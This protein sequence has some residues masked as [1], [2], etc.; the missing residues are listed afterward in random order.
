MLSNSSVA[1]GVN[2]AEICSDAGLKLVPKQL[3]LLNELNNSITNN[4]F[5]NIDQ[6]EFIEPA[7]LSSSLGNEQE[8]RIGKV[9]V[10][11]THDGIM[12][13][14]IEDLSKLV[15]GYISFARNVVNKE[16]NLLKENVEERLSNYK[17]KEAEDFFNVKYFKLDNV[18][19][20]Y[21][22]DNE[23]KTYRDSSGKYFFDSMSLRKITEEDFDLCKYILTGD[24]EQ[25]LV[26]QSWFNAVG[27]EK[28]TGLIIENIREYNLSVDELL[29]YSLVNYLFY[30]NLVEK[31]DLD[32][33][34]SSVQLRSKATSNR[35]YFG[36]KLCIA[37]DLYRKDIRNG[38]L[39]SSNSDVA[40][41]YF[42]TNALN[43]TVYEESF[44]K[45]AEAGCN[46]EVLFGFI[47]SSNTNN[48]TV[49]ELVNNKEN[50]LQKWNNTRSLYL[51][52]INNNRLDI[53][54]QLLRETYESSL[55]KTDL[56]EEEQGF[57]NENPKFLEES[58]CL[59]NAYIDQLHLSDIDDV[60]S[61]CL[62]LV[63]KIRYRFT[64]SYYI[65]REMKEILCLSDNVQPLE[66]ALFATIRYI[67]D[68]LVD[69]LDIV[70]F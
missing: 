53:F 65:L 48:I 16:V 44:A 64:N 46:I 5:T 57:L 40:F 8:N 54:K 9:Y 30:R 3:T 6:R 42:N 19:N 25:D 62:D 28:A 38:K 66:A 20:S 67:T 22:V 36:N 70:K 49:D 7:I 47:S 33:G 52:S 4:L 37:L 29:D 15:T 26:I 18:F 14:Y 43:I 17:Y 61:I 2:L 35:D 58:R 69:Q 11:S 63:A 55:T 27:K 23:I 50:Y 31:N 12:D 51:I 21:L 59:G 10:Q 39:L 1:I 41:S 45:L 13:N 34:Y 24:E 60:D 68:Y 32:L 56:S